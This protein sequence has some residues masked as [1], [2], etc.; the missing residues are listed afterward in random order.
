MLR[1]A[2]NGVKGVRSASAGRG[3][4]VAQ[5]NPDRHQTTVQNKEKLK[6]GTWI[7]RTMYQNG[8]LENIKPEM[9]RLQINILGISGHTAKDQEQ[10]LKTT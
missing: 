6:V 10:L 1:K 2:K 7:V 5:V 3:N 8:K 4:H 9:E